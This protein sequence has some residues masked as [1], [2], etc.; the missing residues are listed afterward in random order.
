MGLARPNAPYGPIRHLALLTGLGSAEASVR[1]AAAD[2]WVRA[3][4]AGQLDPELAADALAEGVTGGAIKLTRLVDGLRYA[5][6]EP[7]AA[8]MAARAVFASADRLVPA[9]PPNLHLLLELTREIGAGATLPE[10][11]ESIV[12]LAAGNDSTRLAAAARQLA[13]P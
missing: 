9:S 4:L 11:P 2:V 7:A 1:I 8:L 5:S 3:G 10:P 12:A 6:R 13:E